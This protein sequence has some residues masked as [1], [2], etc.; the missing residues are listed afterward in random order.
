M[1][2][3]SFRLRFLRC[4]TD[5]IRI[6]AP[7]WECP[8]GEGIPPLV[9]R[10]HGAEALI[11]DSEVLVFESEGWPSQ[12]AAA[13][14]AERYVPALALTLVKL[15]V[16]ADFG[17][18]APKSAFTRAGLR[19]LETESRPRVLNDVHG[20]MLYESEPRPC[21]ATASLDDVCAVGQRRF[22][23]VFS[24]A[25]ELAVRPT[26]RERV[27]LDFFNASFFQ[28][29]PDSRL[30]MLVMAIEAILD[31][32]ARAG[33]ALA[34]VESMIAATRECGSL[35]DDEKQSLLGS[36]EWLKYKSIRQTGRKLASSVLGERKYMDKEAPAFFLYCYDLRSRLVHSSCP[37]PTQ[38]ELRCAVAPL[39]A[40]VSDLLSGDLRDIELA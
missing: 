18:R 28:Q 3:F 10:S 20:L 31:P 40:F 11:K 14:A 13:Q 17:R 27:A 7:R 4:P 5:T 24:K 2:S 26:E 19:M 1:P 36:L 23:H 21:F 38:E 12:E 8:I 22:E 6:D 34:H 39:K 9:L 25:L 16:G 35:S 29:S 33:E 32:P 15:R 30:L 37:L